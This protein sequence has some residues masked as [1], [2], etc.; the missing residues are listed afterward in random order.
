[1]SLPF[2]GQVAVVTG[3]ASGLG[4]EVAARLIDLGAD[5]I[6]NFR[7]DKGDLDSLVKRAESARKRAILVQG[8]VSDD[9]T[10][11]KIAQK[12]A[13]WGRLDVLIN[14]AGVTKHVP[15]RNLAGLDA[16]DFARIF[17]VNVVAPYQLVRA[18]KPFLDAAHAQ[19]GTPRSIIM[20][21]SVAG[22]LA[23]GSSVAYSASK[24]ALNNMTLALARV[25]APANAVCPGYIDTPW[26]EKGTSEA[27]AQEVRDGIGKVLPLGMGAK[28]AEIARS[29]V[30]LCTD[31]FMHMTGTTIVIDD[32]LSLV[33][34]S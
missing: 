34:L 23:N 22:I 20:V 16:E 17:A 29:I 19:S 3:A 12:V 18:L 2:T 25:A 4:Y 5:T 15:H 21:S 31:D 9:E 8:D 28:P 26:F 10:C 14:N 6:L 24:A 30:A 13:E 32:G 27:R 33:G 7:T 11:A 1:M